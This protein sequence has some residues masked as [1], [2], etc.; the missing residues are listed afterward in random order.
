MAKQ[1]EQFVIQTFSWDFPQ[2][3]NF[4]QILAKYYISN[5]ENVS[6][7]SFCK[8]ACMSTFIIHQKL[9]IIQF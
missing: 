5:Q 3:V 1:K 7:E 9:V 4:N 2:Q 8:P 6:A